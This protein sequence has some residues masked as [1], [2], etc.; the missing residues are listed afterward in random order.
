VENRFFLR[1]DRLCGANCLFMT[2]QMALTR[3]KLLF[4]AT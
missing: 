2:A 4:D 3:K 1:K